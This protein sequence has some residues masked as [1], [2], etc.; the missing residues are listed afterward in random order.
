VGRSI[1]DTSG[2]G[3][4]SLRQ[5]HIISKGLN[6]FGQGN[7]GTYAWEDPSACADDVSHES[8]DHRHADDVGLHTANSHWSGGSMWNLTGK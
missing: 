4:C 3:A 5:L 8:F 1:A 7:V 2:L 6:I